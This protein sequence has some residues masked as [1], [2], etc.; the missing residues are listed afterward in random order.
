MSADVSQCDLWVS[1]RGQSEGRPE[2]ESG[3]PFPFGEPRSLA[4]S[5]PCGRSAGVSVNT[6]P[7]RLENAV[8]TVVVHFPSVCISP[9]PFINV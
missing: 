3:C 7:E 8:L 9:Q 2:L 4:I 5:V 6:R 1:A